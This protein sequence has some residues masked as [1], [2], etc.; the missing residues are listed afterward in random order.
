MLLF[1]RWQI[2]HQTINVF[3]WWQDFFPTRHNITIFARSILCKPYFLRSP[4]K[5]LRA[6]QC[7]LNATHG[8]VGPKKEFFYIAY[9]K[10]ID[11]FRKILAMPEDYIINRNFYETYGLTNEWNEA[12]SSLPNDSSILDFILNGDLRQIKSRTDSV[13]RYYT[14]NMVILFS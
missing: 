11:E 13:L 5:Y 3:S 6:I 8:V 10:D 2:T 4:F 12:F 9:G 1:F 7:I 14:W